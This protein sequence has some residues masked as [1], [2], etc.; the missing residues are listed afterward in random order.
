MS[1]ELLFKIE[2]SDHP[3]A[4]VRA[5]VVALAFTNL[6][7]AV[8]EFDNTILDDAKAVQWH[9]TQMEVG[10]AAWA[11]S[12]E[13]KPR[14]QAK[15][16][17]NRTAMVTGFVDLLGSLKGDFAPKPTALGEEGWAKIRTALKKVLA[18]KYRFWVGTEESPMAVMLDQGALAQLD[19][20][21]EAPRVTIGSIEG[22]LDTLQVHDQSRPQFAIWDRNARRVTCYFEEDL[23]DEVYR[24]MRQRVRVRGQIRRRRDGTPLEV[25]VQRL[26]PIPASSQLPR[27]ADMIGILDLGMSAEDYVRSLRDVE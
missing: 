13:F 14:Y 15:A 10:S 11:I 21:L 7:E 9:V 25:K 20:W 26:S 2:H 5:D 16:E 22:R 18:G 24:C 12:P 3:D 4:P 17:I 19:R 27:V 23:Y 6:L 1:Q 8:K